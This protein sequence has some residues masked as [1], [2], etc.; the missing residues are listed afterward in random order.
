[1]SNTGFTSKFETDF[2]ILES[3]FSFDTGSFGS[4]FKVRPKMVEFNN[5]KINP[6][7]ELLARENPQHDYVSEITTVIK[8]IPCR[9][10]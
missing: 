8:V 10:L 2:E 7:M 4:M 9:Y 5:T 1:M 6:L 3:N